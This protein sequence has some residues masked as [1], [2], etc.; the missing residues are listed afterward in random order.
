MSIQPGT[1]VKV[2]T[3]SGSELEKVATS[4]IVKGHDFAV[5]W[6]TSPSDWSRAQAVGDKPQA[7]PWPAEDV[8]I[9]SES[10]T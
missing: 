10:V 5:V 4:G 3:A 1:V 8:R 7:L 6:V 9:V 2:K